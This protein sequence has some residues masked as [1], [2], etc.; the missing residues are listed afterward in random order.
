[1]TL[2]EES[3]LER[4]RLS[5]EL[6]RLRLAAGKTSTGLAQDTGMS[7]SKLSKIENCLLLPSVQ[8][9]QRLLAAL[10]AP[11]KVCAELVALTTQLH[12]QV[13]ARRVVLHRGA[14]RHQRVTTRI[15]NR[16]TTSRLFQHLGVPPLLQSER[17][18]RAALAALSE[19]DQDAALQ[20]LLTR[21]IRLDKPTKNVV[22]VLTEAALRWRVG[23]A[24]VMCEQIDHLRQMMRRPNVQIGV[25]PLH[26]ITGVVD[27]TSFALY[28]DT[29]VVVNM[30]VGN[31][32][33]TDP[34]DVLEYSELFD[35]LDQ[36]T[37]R[38]DRLGKL[39]TDL[40]KNHRAHG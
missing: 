22:V 20:T 29:A 18:L 23:P 2:T 38:G 35:R 11:K 34:Q 26:A 1:M 8:D 31:A 33:I 13:D 16:A 37:V 19:R 32:T 30:L 12:T 27:P 17:Y 6:R 5:A 15:E 3:R 24:A 40:S 25:I 28:D 9:V 4:Q 14:E 7:Q 36:L 21:R 39:L 10:S